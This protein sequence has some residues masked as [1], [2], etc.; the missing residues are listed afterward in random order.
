MLQEGGSFGVITDEVVEHL[1]RR[2]AEGTLRTSRPGFI[3]GQALVIEQGPLRMV[4]AIF[5]RQ[6]DAP[7]RVRILVRLLG[8]SVTV[9]VDP[10]ILRAAS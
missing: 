6:L 1:R 4:D 7:T 8:R 3:A 10:A 2:L 5:E 9:D